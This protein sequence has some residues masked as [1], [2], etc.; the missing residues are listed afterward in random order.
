M[1]ARAPLLREPLAIPL[2]EARAPL[3]LALDVGTSGLRAFVFDAK[4]RPIGPA[5]AWSRKAP[6]TSRLGEASL[7]ADERARAA[8]ACIDGVMRALGRRGGDVAAVA[9]S[10]FWHSL[11]GVDASGRATTRV[12]TWADTRPREAAA[13]LRAELDEGEMHARTGCMLHASYLP[14]KLRWLRAAARETYA[15][16]AHWMSF[17]EYLYLRAFGERRAAH[18]MASATGLYRQRDAAWDP[19]IL[20]HLGLDERSLSPI[21]DEPLAGLRPALA[22]RW[23]ALAHVPWIPAIGD[24]ACSNVGCGAVTRGTAALMVGTSGALR[25][26]RETADAPVVKGGWTY[27]LDA[28]RV[29]A[30]GA[31]SNGGNALAWIARAFPQVDLESAV[32][33]PVGAHGLTAL[34]L[35]AGDRS[36]SWDDAARASIAGMGLGTLP[37]DVVQAFVE[38]IVCRFARLWQVV[39]EALPGIERVIATGGDAL[40]RPYLVQLLADALGRPLV[41][42]GAG[43]G[44]ARGAAIVALERI[45]AITDLGSVRSPL[46]RVFRPRERAQAAFREAVERQARVEEAL[47]EVAS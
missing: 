3:V 35:L 27:R 46:G 16:T 38:G 22:R 13:V 36:P 23:P 21:S 26:V 25:V 42:S 9:V 45:G 24:G 11:L 8:F 28:R 30:G 7:D 40:A 15:G 10:T 32:R 29:V 6:R 41:A 47:A 1:A 18:G 2:R 31:L 43:E 20:G 5:V 37:E 4:A 14:A 39:D 44:S 17:G 12:I 34:P 33:R 19:A